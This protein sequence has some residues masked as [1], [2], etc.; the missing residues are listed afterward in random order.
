[1]CCG[2]CRA[3]RRAAGRSRAEF[4]GKP[5]AINMVAIN[6]VWLDIR[7]RLCFPD[8]VSLCPGDKPQTPHRIPANGSAAAW[9]VDVG[10]RAGFMVGGAFIPAL[11][12]CLLPT[13][14]A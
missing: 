14:K 12:S 6:T 2:I 13:G 11:S 4:R 7:T 10:R 9:T 3:W 1:M 5:S 8:Y